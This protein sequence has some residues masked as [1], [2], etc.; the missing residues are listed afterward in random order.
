MEQ[1]IELKKQLLELQNRL[2]EVINESAAKEDEK[3]SALA[4]IKILH[5]QIEKL[6]V[7]FF[8]NFILNDIWVQLFKKNYNYF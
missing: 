6:S 2:V 4:N 1:N 7:K 3:L 8:F 5:A